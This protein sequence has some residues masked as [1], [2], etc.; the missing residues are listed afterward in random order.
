MHLCQELCGE[1]RSQ[2]QAALRLRAENAHCKSAYMG[3]IEPQRVTLSELSSS[4][5][6]RVVRGRVPLVIDFA[7][8]LRSA[9]AAAEFSSEGNPA[10]GD[11]L[12][13]LTDLGRHGAGSFRDGR[14]VKSLHET[15]SDYST[16]ESLYVFG[17]RVGPEA[18]ARYR[19]YTASIVSRLPALSRFMDE[20][21]FFLASGRVDSGLHYDPELNA[22]MH[23]VLHG[24]KH[25]TLWMPG[26]A[27]LA[28][29]PLTAQ[30]GLQFRPGSEV[31]S[32]HS[33][34]AVARSATAKLGAAHTRQ[35]QDG[36]VY[37]LWLRAG[38]AL[39]MPPRTWHFIQYAGPS[40]AFGVPFYATRTHWAAGFASMLWYSG[41]EPSL[42]L[43]DAAPYH[44]YAAWH[45]ELDLRFPSAAAVVEAGLYWLMAPL[46]LLTPIVLHCLESSN[47]PKNPNQWSPSLPV[48]KA[49]GVDGTGEVPP[50]LILG[51]AVCAVW[52]VLMLA[53][54][55][56]Y[57][58]RRLTW[59]LFERKQGRLK[60]D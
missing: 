48:V 60:R 37:M 25:L 2:G 41:F 34:S 17:Y 9:L 14:K 19:R 59:V 55:A 29:W 1:T 40:I 18:T 57:V 52:Q 12:S 33:F 42:G 39:Y 35:L 5:D 46:V 16:N 30:S 28:R 36:D 51:L 49:Q 32:P 50:L 22:N 27:G 44:R 47:G 31:L 58:A 4:F 20:G 3:V 43:N 54:A 10:W 38:E 23:L 11:S 26:A 53:L 6:E 21:Q 56:R 7:S 13:F 15:I 45:W 24:A 8:E